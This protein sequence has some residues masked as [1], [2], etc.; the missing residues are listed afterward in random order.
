MDFSKAKA[1]NKGTENEP[2]QTRGVC[3]S[4]CDLAIYIIKKYLKAKRRPMK[5]NK[6]FIMQKHNLQKIL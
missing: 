3:K 4:H 6:Y 2:K 5:L 1:K